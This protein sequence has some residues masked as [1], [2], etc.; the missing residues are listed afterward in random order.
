MSSG[1]SDPDYVLAL[2]RR[3][4]A[5]GVS[6]SVIARS[7]ATWQSRRSWRPNGE[8]AASAAVGGLLA[9]TARASLGQSATGSP[10]PVGTGMTRLPRFVRG[11]AFCVL[12]HF[13]D[14]QLD[15]QSEPSL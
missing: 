8:I 2:K 4:G 3:A 13:S 10:D 15:I 1:L 12:I 7:E 11:V 14:T 5:P 9:M 6:E